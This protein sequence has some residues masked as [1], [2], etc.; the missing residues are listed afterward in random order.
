M[1]SRMKQLLV[2]LM[3]LLCTGI[4]V[5]MT[6]ESGLFTASSHSVQSATPLFTGDTRWDAGAGQR[7]STMVPLNTTSGIAVFDDGKYCQRPLHVEPLPLLSDL[8]GDGILST[9]TVSMSPPLC[10]TLST[11]Q[12][13][14]N[15][16]SFRDLER[17][18]SAAPLDPRLLQT[19]GPI[20]ERDSYPCVEDAESTSLPP[21]IYVPMPCFAADELETHN[22]DSTPVQRN[23]GCEDR[24]AT[25]DDVFLRVGP[26]IGLRQPVAAARVLCGNT[27]VLAAIDRSSE[28]L[29]FNRCA[30][31]S[32]QPNPLDELV[33]AAQGVKHQVE[34][35]RNTNGS[36]ADEV[37]F[38]T[39]ATNFYPGHAFEAMVTLMAHYFNSGLHK[40]RVPWLLTM[41]GLDAKT[42]FEQFF[43]EV[44]D[45]LQL[46]DPKIH[47]PVAYAVIE[48]AGQS[49]RRQGPRKRTASGPLR[50]YHCKRVHFA[51]VWYGMRSSCAYPWVVNY[52]IPGALV[53]AASL[54]LSRQFKRVVVGLKLGRAESG[55]ASASRSFS[56]SDV[57]RAF[58]QRH[59]FH[60]PNPGKVL[61]LAERIWYT[62]HADFI[63]TGWGSSSTILMNSLNITRGRELRVLLLVHPGYNSEFDR[64]FRGSPGHFPGENIVPQRGSVFRGALQRRDAALVD[65]CGDKHFRVKILR[66]A[67]L[68]E[69][70]EEDLDF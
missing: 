7:E 26:R 12:V 5:A 31:W 17:L 58:F 28:Y 33:H 39:S 54:G 20:A 50:V 21:Y 13:I 44:I 51:P 53:K 19:Q 67:S 38:T 10:I 24:V 2:I 35:P 27:T 3:L 62:E 11:T 46:M 59:R 41:E 45:L 37:L 15:F 47:I 56:L 6:F 30:G 18:R 34:R 23:C 42:S 9:D 36:D 65:A 55:I 14:Y 43:L 64:Y 66:L 69:L 68:D 70:T 1:N 52:L 40:R 60:V 25:V 16:S 61:S 63:I 57:S 29:D 4:F 49:I 22:N 8:G 48:P 32:D